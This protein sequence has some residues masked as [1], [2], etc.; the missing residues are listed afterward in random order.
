MLKL[1]LCKLLA[2]AT[3]SCVAFGQATTTPPAPKPA[4][5]AKP[6]KPTDPIMWVGNEALTLERFEAIL[7]S[8]PGGASAMG[9]KQFASQYGLL[10][11][12]ARMG[13]QQKIDQTQE[14]KDQVEFMRMQMLAQQTFAKISVHPPVSDADVEKHYKEHMNEFQQVKVRGIFVALAPTGKET[15]PRTEAEAK[16]LALSLRKKIADGAAFADVAKASSDEP[17]TAAKG[18]DFGM[19]RKGQLPP[20]IEKAV[21]ALKPKEISEPV[22][23]ARGYYLFTVDEIRTMTLDEATPQIRSQLEQSNIGAIMEDVKKKYPVK[24]NDD[25]FEAPA[26]APGAPKK[27]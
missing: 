14:F 1:S 27:Q 6:V 18:G 20:N 21:F 17:A 4:P 2:M 7:K 5:E 12:L 3:I 9:K 11:G 23:E 13:E 19:V 16:E 25:Y 8:A 26:P 15:K 24:F 10:L 22:Q